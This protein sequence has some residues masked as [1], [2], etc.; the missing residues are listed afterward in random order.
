[1][2]LSKAHKTII[3]NMNKVL[4]IVSAILLSTASILKA[5]RVVEILPDVDTL[6]ICADSTLQLNA[7]TALSYSWSPANIFD[8][9][10]SQTPTITP[11]APTL[12]I[13]DAI[14][15]GFPRKDSIFVI[16]TTPSLDLSSDQSGPVCGGEVVTVFS[17]DNVQGQGLTWEFP[18]ELFILDSL[19]SRALVRPLRHVTLTATLEI[20]GCTVTEDFLVEVTPVAA[21]IDNPDTVFLC[22]GEEVDLTAM[23]TGNQG[24]LLFW[25]PAEGLSDTVG[26]AVTAAPEE[27]TTYYTSFTLDGCTIR[28]SV[29]VRID[30]IP[31]D[32][33]LE[34]DEDKETY[35][36]GDVVTLKSPTF[37]PSAYPIIEHTWS[38]ILTMPDQGVDPVGS[39]GFETP[40]SLFNMVFTA[41][42]SAIYR[43]IT[44]SGGCVDTSE[45]LIPVIQ[46]KEITITPDPAVVCPGQTIMLTAT[47]EGEGEITWMP[48]EL[49]SGANDEREVTVGPLLENTEIEIEVEEEDCPSNASIQVQV[50]PSLIDLNT[51]TVIC[52]GEDIQLNFTNLPGVNYQ[53]SSP[54]DPSF[55]TMDPLINVNPTENTTYQLAA[56]FGDCPEETSQI[57]IQVINPVTVDVTPATLTICPREE[58]TLSAMGDAAAGATENYTWTFQGSSQNGPDITIRTLTED[59]TFLMTYLALKPSG[60]ECFRATAEAQITVEQQPEIVDYDF[61]PETATTDG[62]FLGES[63]GVAANIVGITTGYDFQ[64]MANDNNIDGA[65]PDI[66]DTPSENTVYKLTLTSPN[67]CVTELPSPPVLVIIPQYSIPNVFTPNDDNVNDFFNIAFV[68]IQDL[69]AFIQEF[70]VF[71]RWG[72][73]VYDNETPE[74]GWDGNV[75][76]NPAASDVYVYKITVEFPDGR[77]EENSGEVTLIR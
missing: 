12:V 42:D 72:Q 77:R 2:K 37:N 63:V 68:G 75:N 4:L 41:Q 25:S 18:E 70:R 15:N 10:T 6:F 59:A 34:K 20:T 71:N 55:N 69:S 19:K 66:T 13:L 24:E 64:W 22:A 52:E 48:E 11:T 9:P 5:Q 3:Q 73:I 50:L 46:P 26:L 53:W 32:L 43:R 38:T 58:F 74:T 40:D 29:V 51:E 45:V 27:T 61:N 28:D 17:G 57:Q 23:A 16:P 1:M 47:F 49:I 36:I 65:G 30:S 8:D 54:N 44:T 39:V 35:C 67:D 60:Q 33:S 56:Q 14:V 62:I 21:V 31:V 7:S 76:G